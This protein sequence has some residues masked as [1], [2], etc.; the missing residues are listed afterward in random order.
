MVFHHDTRIPETVKCGR[1]SVRL[2]EGDELG[3]KRVP[4]CLYSI[5]N[6]EL[7]PAMKGS[8]LGSICFNFFKELQL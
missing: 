8:D 2:S 1:N 7:G 4:S 5:K 3:D 6:M